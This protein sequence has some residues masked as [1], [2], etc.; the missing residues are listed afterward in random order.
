LGHD[1]PN[2]EARQSELF[3]R[4]IGPFPAPLNKRSSERR[5]SSFSPAQG[6]VLSREFLISARPVVYGR[7]CLRSILMIL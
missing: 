6:S 5:A 7:K 3:Q 2:N 4:E 1:Q